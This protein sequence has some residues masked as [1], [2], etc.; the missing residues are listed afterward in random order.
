MTDSLSSMSFREKSAWISLVSFVAALSVFLWT[1]IRV[2]AGQPALEPSLQLLL[3]V[4]LIG[5]NGVLQL[6]IAL[7]S[8]KDARTPKDERERL[9]ELKATRPAF[10]VLLVS[11]VASVGTVH[12]PIGPLAAHVRVMM[13]GVMLSVALAGIVKFGTQIVLHRRDR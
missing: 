12:L 2:L 11:A 4:A 8:P 6:A 5:V 10:F 9:I 7:R 3:L 13:M 1:A